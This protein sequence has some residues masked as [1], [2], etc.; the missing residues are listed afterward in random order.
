MAYVEEEFTEEQEEQE[1]EN[2]KEWEK[3][4]ICPEFQYIEYLFNTD[5]HEDSGNDAADILLPQMNEDRLCDAI[6]SAVDD[7]PFSA[8]TGSSEHN[9]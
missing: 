1:G 7:A 8:M 5:F 2:F 4:Y 9:G 3:N 6:N